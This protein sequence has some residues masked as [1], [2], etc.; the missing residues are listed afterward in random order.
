MV[1]DAIRSVIETKLKINWTTTPVEWPNFPLD[2]QDQ[3]DGSGKKTPWVRLTI[4]DGEA[5]NIALGG[6]H[7]RYR[8]IVIIGIFVPEKSGTG[9]ARAYAD[10][11]AAIFQNQDDQ[12]VKFGVPSYEDI[13][14]TQSKRGGN[15]GG[16]WFQGNLTVGFVYDNIS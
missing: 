8:G 7:Q 15:S 4:I 14:P 11:L 13:G 5:Q 12:G 6:G 2:Q 16:G 10:I 1:F 3:V 9:M